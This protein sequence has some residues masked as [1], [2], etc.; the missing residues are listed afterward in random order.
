MQPA[1]PPVAEA[2]VSRQQAGP[3]PSW[4]ERVPE[5]CGR[6]HVVGQQ[7]G[8]GP[9]LLLLPLAVPEEELCCCRRLGWCPKAEAME[10]EDESVA[11]RRGMAAPGDVL[12]F[13]MADVLPIMLLVPS[14]RG[15]PGE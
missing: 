6:Q 7:A 10:E 2:G 9:T 1:S 5:V 14:C 8:G 15:P 13:P 3:T 12:V 4:A 11:V